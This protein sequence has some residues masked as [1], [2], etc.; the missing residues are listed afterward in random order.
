MLQE[1]ARLKIVALDTPQTGSEAMSGTPKGDATP[2]APPTPAGPSNP[3]HVKP[4]DPVEQ[5]KQWLL[6]KGWIGVVAILVFLVWWEWDHI[7]TLPFVHRTASYFTR[8][9]I[10]RAPQDKFTIVLTHLQDDPDHENEK[11]LLAELE[12][13]EGISVL[14]VD[15]AIQVPSTAA[16]EENLL[17]AHTEARSILA[18]SKGHVILWGSIVRHDQRSAIQLRWTTV[19]AGPGRRQG[20]RYQPDVELNLP[21]VF[22]EDLTQLLGLLVHSELQNIIASQGSFQAAQL[23]P[24]VSATRNL[25]ASNRASWLPRDR[26][27]V[28]FALAYALVAL[29]DESRDDSALQEAISR[30]R[31]II[32]TWTRSENPLP[33]AMTQNLLGNALA[34]RG[35]TNGKR[36][37]EEA[38]S[39]YKA[40]LSE[41]TREPFPA[42][43]AATQSNLGNTLQTLGEL[44]SGTNYLQEA[45]AAQQAALEVEP[46]ESMPF[47]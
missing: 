20:A 7:A 32:E 47:D 33:W 11:L 44:D 5:I 43:W 46:R 17:R 1:S 45:I 27:P 34:I 16:E 6:S 41:Y 42:C 14:Q 19:P 23:R 39:A 31:S 36:Y 2:P 28:E 21:P 37:L 38:V 26:T 12:K 30:S 9:P 22:W 29:G 13:F 25:L 18:Q 15:R 40:A 4:I 35:Q 8:G 24:F 3:E 10:P